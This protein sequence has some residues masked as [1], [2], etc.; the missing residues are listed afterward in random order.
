[1]DDW[2]PWPEGQLVPHQFE[3]P[4]EMRLSLFCQAA[5]QGRISEVSKVL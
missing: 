3:S 5:F 2:E 4:E 1:M